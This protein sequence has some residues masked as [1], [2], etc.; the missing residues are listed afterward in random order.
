MKRKIDIKLKKSERDR[1]H[2]F[3]KKGTAKA[4]EI[5]RAQ[6]LLLGNRRKSPSIISEM[7]GPTLTTIQ[8]IKKRYLEGG[9]DRA[10]F[11]A[12]R[13]GQ[14]T[15]FSG[16]AKAKIT[17]LACTEAPEGHGR[18]TLRLLADRAVELNYVESISHTKVADILKKTQ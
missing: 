9:L 5:T 11:D 13:P 2:R 8:N 4:R 6:V 15:L 10:L 12:P 17:A 3:I 14:P 1:L 16:K 7:L 18:W